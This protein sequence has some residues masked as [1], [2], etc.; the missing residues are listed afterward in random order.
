MGR[1]ISQLPK[2][3]AN[4]VLDFAGTILEKCCHLVRPC[5]W[6]FVTEDL[7][8]PTA[9]G[10]L[11]IQSLATLSVLNVTNIDTFVDMIDRE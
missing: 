1:T 9:A 7:P 10:F 11:L 2:N 4:F 8:L 6:E 3:L 5:A